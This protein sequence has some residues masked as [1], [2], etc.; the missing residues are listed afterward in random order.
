MTR[1]ATI[2]AFGQLRVNGGPTIR[3]RIIQVTPITLAVFPEASP[4]SPFQVTLSE[5][6]R[7]RGRVMTAALAD[8]GGTLEFQRAGCGCQTPSSLRGPAGRFLA[9]LTVASDA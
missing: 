3:A 1:T 8:D 4:E 2:D 9:R 5:P 6:P 7:I